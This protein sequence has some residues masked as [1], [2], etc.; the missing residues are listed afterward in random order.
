MKTIT[1]NSKTNI[2]I[3][4]FGTWQLTGNICFLAVGAAL[5]IGYRHLDTAWRYDNH[6][7][8]GKAIKQS[9]LKREQLFITSKLWLPDLVN[10][11]VTDQLQKSLAQLQINYLDLY[12]IHWPD[13]NLSM[14]R[15]LLEMKKLKTKGLIRAIGVSNFTI[16]HLQDALKTGVEIVDNQVE[17][18]PSLNQ[19]KLKDFCDQHQIALTAYSPIAQGQ[20][21]KLPLIKKLA[22]KYGKSESQIILNWLI[23]K[24]MA[25]IPRASNPIHIADNYRTTEW[26]LSTKD[27]TLIDKLNTNNRIINPPFSDFDY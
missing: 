22:S 23:S 3:L 1:L 26:Q 14:E 13:R 4:G 19:K 15:I 21:L 25:A 10:Y 7:E 27:I 17:F 24:G 16:H 9:G 8:I 5:K 20:D 11:K 6:T 18:H 2:P 12:L